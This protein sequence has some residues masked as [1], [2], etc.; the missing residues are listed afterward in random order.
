MEGPTWGIKKVSNTIT[1]KLNKEISSKSKKIVQDT[2][3]KFTD[4]DIK[5]IADSCYKI[6]SINNKKNES[7]RDFVATFK[8]YHD[9]YR[10]VINTYNELVVLTS[11]N[12]DSKKNVLAYYVQLIREQEKEQGISQFLLNEA[13]YGF[14]KSIISWTDT[15]GALDKISSINEK[16]LENEKKKTK[17][18]SESK[19]KMIT[20]DF[21][22]KEKKK[23]HWLLEL[24]ISNI[25]KY[26]L[27]NIDLTF[28]DNMNNKLRLIEAEGKNI[29]I[30]SQGN[31]AQI[32]FLGVSMN[33]RLHENIKYSLKGK[34][35]DN[36]E[37]LVLIEASID[38]P[39][40][41]EKEKELFDVS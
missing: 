33:E 16:N 38:N 36:F 10:M 18:S 1:E 28:L 21:I 27:Q 4:K 24:S 17:K 20:L 25:S 9:T 26:P 40:K 14:M 37:N 7:R 34:L 15:P 6:R 3:N 19:S 41:R 11:K 30:A 22:D 23:D 35:E 39:G 5:A 29:S 13:K 32:A 31:T 12:G 8:K 2:V